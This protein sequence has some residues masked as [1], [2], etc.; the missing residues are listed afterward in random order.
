MAKQLFYIDTISNNISSYIKN[1]NEYDIDN[2]NNVYNSI[3][4][5]IL[6]SKYV[7]TITIDNEEK[8]KIISKYKF[9]NRIILDIPYDEITSSKEIMKFVRLNP[10]CIIKKLHTL[11]ITDFIGANIETYELFVTYKVGIDFC[12]LPKM[13]IKNLIITEQENIK[14]PNMEDLFFYISTMKFLYDTKIESLTLNINDS[15]YY[16]MIEGFKFPSSLKKLIINI[17]IENQDYNPYDENIIDRINSLKFLDNLKQLEDFECNYLDI[18]KEDFYVE[19][20]LLHPNSD[21]LNSTLIYADDVE[22]EI[23]KIE[24]T[25]VKLN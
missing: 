15:L 13:N 19:Y 5:N 1:K 7:D 25:V 3:I 12:N 22:M 14:R 21:N 20:L 8:L 23:Y 18:N 9:R 24:K 17:Q 16:Y 10:T 6:N 2:F 4:T 11:N